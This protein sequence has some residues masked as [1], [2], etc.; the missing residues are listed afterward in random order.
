[1][2]DRWFAV[3]RMAIPFVA[4]KIGSY[5]A[6][7]GSSVEEIYGD[8]LRGRGA[9]AN[10]LASMVFSTRRSFRGMALPVEAQ[11]RRLSELAWGYGWRRK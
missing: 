6:Y 3:V 10:T 4:E 11:W 5:E 9:E 7:G 1:M 8:K 2:P